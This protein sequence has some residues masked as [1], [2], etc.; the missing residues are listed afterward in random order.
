MV[1]ALNTR[2]IEKI[3]VKKTRSRYN[4]CLDE[5]Q[6]YFS[7]KDKLSKDAVHDVRVNLKRVDALIALLQFNHNSPS[8]KKLEAFKSLFKTAGK[9]RSVQVEFDLI[10]KYF[11]DNKLNP[12]YLHHVHEV[13]SE[14]LKEYSELLE[15]G[16]KRLAEGIQSLKKKISQITKRQMLDYLRSEEKNLASLIERSIFREQELHFIRKKLK[17]LHLNLQISGHDR[18]QLDKLLDLLGYWH[19]HQIA[20]DHVIKALHVGRLSR[21]ESAPI[22]KIKDDLVND[23]ENLYEKVVSFYTTN[24]Q[25]KH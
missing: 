4:D 13:K 9:L 10:N 15:S 3:D 18:K 8:K 25:N 5:I 23:K 11:K 22:K 16:P 21:S 12:K 20:Y 24:M 19:D 1:R 6:K 14:K 17:K 2:P 7:L